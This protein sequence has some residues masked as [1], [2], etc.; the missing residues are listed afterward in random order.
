VQRQRA[1]A[2]GATQVERERA[3]LFEL[4]VEPRVVQV[5]AAATIGLGPVHRDVGLVQQF[6]DARRVDAEARG[7]DARATEHALVGR[8]EGPTQ[9]VDHALGQVTHVVGAG[10][11]ALQHREFIAAQARQQVAVAHQ[12]TQALGGLAQDLVAGSVPHA[13]R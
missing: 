11:R 2:H 9:G 4:A 8:I 5:E 7:T 1:I 13:C 6:F 10:H 12:A 3:S